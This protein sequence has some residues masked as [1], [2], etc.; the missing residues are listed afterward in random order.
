M[1]FLASTAFM[2]IG[3]S[4]IYS[5]GGKLASRAEFFSKI[6]GIANDVR[7]VSKESIEY[8]CANHTES[9]PSLQRLKSNFFIAQISSIQQRIQSCEIDDTEVTKSLTALRRS[10]TLDSERPSEVPPEQKSDKIAE[11]IDSSNWLIDTLEQHH[12]QRTKH[13]THK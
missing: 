3:W 11:I 13:D 8:W 10:I 12:A 1:L 5:N 7:N 2:I 6:S 4:V 9:H